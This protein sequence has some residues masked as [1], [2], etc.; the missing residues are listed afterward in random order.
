MSDRVLVPLPSGQWLAL[1]PEAFR[2]ALTDGAS[3]AASPVATA[4]PNDEPLMDAE[5]LAAVL[6][7]PQTWIEDRARRGEI[8][9]IR[10]GRWRRF[11]RRAVEQALARAGT[12][13]A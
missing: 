2:Q 6:G 9:S 7:I 3:I 8:P 11:S 12:D 4:Q 10:A 1:E 13:S 5:Q